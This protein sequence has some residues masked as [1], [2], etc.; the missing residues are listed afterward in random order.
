MRLRTAVHLASPEPG[1]VGRRG[2]TTAQAVDEWWQHWG[3][4]TPRPSCRD[5]RWLLGRNGSNNPGK[6]ELSGTDHLVTER[7]DAI[8]ARQ[9]LED[10]TAEWMRLGKGRG[11]LLDEAE[12]AEAK[13]WLAS[14][15]AAELG[16]GEELPAL[17]HAS[18]VELAREL[19]RLRRRF[20][21]APALAALAL[22]A[23]VAALYLFGRANDEAN[24]RAT[25]VVVRSTAEA[26]ALAN[27]Q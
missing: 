17:V 16:Y 24:A 23:A 5:V 10:K 13:R 14:P 22:V 1:R 12:L 4:D 8:R 20:L 6:V 19:L 11:G 21:A 3:R 27:E 7:G 25:E 2:R 18:W 26:N 9:R 15:D